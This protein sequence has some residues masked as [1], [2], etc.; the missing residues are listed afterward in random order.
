[1]S[2][3]YL[4]LDR[5]ALMAEEYARQATKSLPSGLEEDRVVD[6]LRLRSEQAYQVVDE[7]NAL[8]DMHLNPLLAM[9]SSL[10]PQQAQALYRLAQRLYSCDIEQERGVDR[11]LA[12]SIYEALY[13]YA[14][15]WDNTEMV[16]GCLCHIGQ[17]FSRWGRGLFGRQALKAYRKALEYSPLY[18]DIESK[19]ARRWLMICHLRIHS[20]LIIQMYREE[21]SNM[22]IYFEAVDEAL[23]FY[24]R[25]G[26]REKDPDF[27]WDTYLEIINENSSSMAERLEFGPSI[28]TDENKLRIY[29]SCMSFFSPEEICLLQG[30]NS[31][32][33]RAL[34]QSKTL[35]VFLLAIVRNHTGQADDAEYISWLQDC[36]DTVEP[37]DYSRNGYTNLVV[38]SG[39]L[40]KVLGR[41][42]Q[43]QA[44]Q[45]RLTQMAAHLLAY[46]R[47]MPR[48]VMQEILIM[49]E[50]F[51]YAIDH[52]IDEMNRREYIGIVL[53]C[54]TQ[55][56]LPT[57]VHSVMVGRLMT[58]IAQYFIPR[59]P[60]YFLG[61][62]GTATAAQVLEKSEDICDEIN[63]A[64]L[65]HDIGKVM[66]IDTVSRSS[67]R[68][69]DWEFSQI[70]Q[71]PDEGYNILNRDIF[72]CIPHVIRGHHKH[73]NGQG[74]YPHSF[75][76]TASPY[77]FIIDI[78]TAADCIDAA[79]D[80][81]GRSYQQC[82]TREMVVGELQQAAGTRYNA[83]IALALDDPALAAQIDDTLAGFRKRVYYQAYMDMEGKISL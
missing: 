21:Y 82:K 60:Q 18:Q 2:P 22:D 17:I 70:K 25:P 8:I 39:V 23:E 45:M 29:Q 36:I 13:R 62:C 10:D 33:R 6:F 57:Y 75:D 19:V 51:Q 64:G 69:T 50:N 4:M 41:H 74:G 12:L 68:L 42:P 66:F 71:H 76:N 63:L 78:C 67:R 80:S 65:A 3:K 43:N 7:N 81:I 11:C 9:P 31:P 79:T 16:L 35:L 44:I 54:T 40:A 49:F 24:H 83:E 46:M 73:H 27:P 59:R 20:T 34:L 77:H 32:E 47:G 38:C 53:S 14:A 37:S 72:G 1:M 5:L 15:A 55:N 48:E 56:H 58:Q 52:S 26:V 30:T 28:V 61:M